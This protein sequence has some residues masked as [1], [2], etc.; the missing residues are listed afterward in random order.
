LVAVTAMYESLI[1]SVK[2]V[3]YGTTVSMAALA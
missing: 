3:L 1:A 2:L